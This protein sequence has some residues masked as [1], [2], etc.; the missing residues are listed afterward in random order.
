MLLVNND[1]KMEAAPCLPRLLLSR[2]VFGTTL[3]A[4]SA[5]R[6]RVGVTMV[7]VTT[8]GATQDCGGLSCPFVAPELERSAALR[9][10]LHSSLWNWR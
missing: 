1:L 8:V 4:D 6:R 2:L 7:G 10:S 3:L 9:A 5:L